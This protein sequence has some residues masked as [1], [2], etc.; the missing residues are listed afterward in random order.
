MRLL[1]IVVAII[2]MGIDGVV[3]AYHVAYPSITLLYRLT[4]EAEVDGQPKS[5]SSVIEVT[6]SKQP[7]IGSG[8]NLVWG[9]RGEAVVIELGERGTLFALLKEGD[10]TRSIPPTIVFRAF[11]FSGGIWPQGRVEDLFKTIRQLS[12]RRE[13]PLDNLPMLVRFRDINDPKTVERVSPHNL[14][15]RFGP[16]VRLVRA[17]LEIVP[18]AN[19][20]FSPGHS[21]S[22]PVTTG[23]EQKLAWLSQYF[24]R[25]FDGRRYETISSELRL[26]NSLSSGAFKAGR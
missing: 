3:L 10:D 13:L 12:G 17:T 19:W 16:G 15:E 20:P 11:G 26:A 8:R 22:E 5:G 14:A 23:I 1:G 7:E 18:P 9:Y 6:Y 2:C 24:D 21:K 25:M 4:L